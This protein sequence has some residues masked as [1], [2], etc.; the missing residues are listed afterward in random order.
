M[1]IP[2]IV[3]TNEMKF[4]G[5]FL[6]GTLIAICS[7]LTNATAEPAS[8][9]TIKDTFTN[10]EPDGTPSPTHPFTHPPNTVPLRG[11]GG[12]P[13]PLPTA[14]GREAGYPH[15]ESPSPTTWDNST[16]GKGFRSKM[17]PPTTDA[18]GEPLGRASPPPTD[19]TIEDDYPNFINST[20]N[21]SDALAVGRAPQP[22]TTVQPG[23]LS[24][25]K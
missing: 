12:Q 14:S 8:N 17:P 19:A 3:M 16:E 5:C 10:V 22:A 13:D 24:G 15:D 4:R 23:P 1:R 2:S 7:H 11:G 6:I 20:M 18:D 25:G 21:K 9:S